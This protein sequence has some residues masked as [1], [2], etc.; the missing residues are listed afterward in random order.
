[1]FEDIG[2]STVARTKMQKYLIGRLASD[3]KSISEQIWLA[4]REGDTKALAVLLKTATP[5]D[6]TFEGFDREVRPRVFGFICAGLAALL[7]T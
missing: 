5:A 3:S 6:L 4:A 2:H 7:A 1:M